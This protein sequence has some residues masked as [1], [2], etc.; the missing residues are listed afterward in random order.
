MI[1]P[2]PPPPSDFANLLAMYAD[3]CE[4]HGVSPHIDIHIAISK[5]KAQQPGALKL[6]LE[7]LTEADMM[8]LAD[9]LSFV[10]G[11]EFDAV[12]VVHNK[13]ASNGQALL[14]VLRTIG[15]KLRLVD[16]KKISFGRE[17]LRDLF[18]RGLQC[19]VLDLSFSRARKLDMTGQF[20]QLHTLIL[21]FSRYLT[22][23]PEGCFRAM[24]NL[25]RLSIRETK[26]ANLWTTC[27]ALSKVSSLVELRFQSCRCCEGTGQCT[28]LG[29]TEKSCYCLEEGTRVKS[30]GNSW[31]MDWT[32][33]NFDDSV[34]LDSERSDSSRTDDDS[35]D[36]FSDDD[37]AMML[38]PVHTSSEDSSADSDT[39][40]EGQNLE[41]MSVEDDL[42]YQ[43]DF[44]YD[45]EHA[46][47]D[48]SDVV[49]VQA[50]QGMPEEG[51]DSINRGM[52]IGYGGSLN[53]AAARSQQNFACLEE[54]VEGGASSGEAV[55]GTNQ[56]D[57]KR[58]GSRSSLESFREDEELQCSTSVQRTPMSL[59]RGRSHHPSR[60]CYEKHY[61]EFVI[62]RL[63]G[64]KVLDNLPVTQMEREKAHLVFAEK[65]EILPNNRSE[66]ESIVEVL[67]SRETS[68]W[69]AGALYCK[70]RRIVHVGNGQSSL[71]F[72]RSM[73]ALK[74]ASCAWPSCVPICK[75]KKSNSELNRKCRPRQFEYHPTDAS[76]MVFG[77]LHGE[78]VVVNH[79]CDKVVGY[80]QSNG[81]SHSILGLCWL[82]KDSSKL[83]AG[84]DNGSLQLYD[85]NRM[86]ATTNLSI[87]TVS[88]GNRNSGGNYGGARRN[89]AI[90][91]YDNFEQLTSVHIN[92]TDEYFLASGYSRNVGLYDLCT[93]KQLQIFNDLHQQH[94]NVVKFAH[95]SPHLFA[96]SSFDK[97][98]KMWDLRQRVSKPLYTVHSTRGNVMVCFSRDD[99]YLLSSAVDNEVRQHLAVDGR[100]HM[101]FDIPPTRSSQNYTRS[102]YMNGRDYIITGSCE[103]NVV[104]IYCAQTGR[105]LRDLALEGRG[106][107][108]SIYVQSLR[109]DPFR[110]FHFSVLAAYLHPH[111][112]SE[113]L[114]VNLLASNVQKKTYD[115][116]AQHKLPAGVGA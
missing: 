75:L 109:G 80:V 51:N 6:F 79:E 26:I 11:S 86:R 49:I 98:I 25:A 43:G 94:I 57:L 95:H 97:E 72:S 58:Y 4:K 14:K 34:S 48:E 81:S 74:M 77:T 96:T 102:Y 36:L 113:I 64:L 115:F 100:P 47:V 10:E 69:A 33:M 103:E 38:Q 78:V 63:P 32:P 45:R 108:T 46:F 59:R 50:D 68:S 111:S 15:P 60:I 7:Q 66:R 62:A 82:N 61:R 71:A 70:R 101:K 22:C 83:I 56:N 13:Q 112:K 27:A 87:D 37:S 104:R 89:P 5:A 91:T 18:H 12:D 55:D 99:H 30:L 28:A 29:T 1:P 21:D 76:L 90:Y 52:E 3:A 40:Q 41:T 114:K 20:P 24:P 35:D 106:S 65:F 84:S 93:G 17:T 107:K 73:C 67:K 39:D 19:Q 42:T 85:V 53:Y 54:T 92:S 88:T 2:S 8:P 16:F 23:L 44:E 105:R 110:D 9:F 116:E 31:H